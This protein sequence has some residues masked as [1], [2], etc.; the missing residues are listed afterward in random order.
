MLFNIDL[1]PKVALEEMNDVHLEELSM[2]NDIY[3]YLSRPIDHDQN[4][5]EGMLKEFV[6]H[7]HGHFYNEEQMMKET[8]CPILSCHEGEHQRVLSIMVQFLK[9]YALS[10]DHQML[11]DFFEYEFKA[12]I[13]NHIL[14]MD[15]VTGMYL[16]KISMGE[17]VFHSD[18]HGCETKKSL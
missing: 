2:A 13:E 1:M 5:I 14:T 8:N 17:N 15:T 16:S 12:W 9:D 6:L 10:K 3:D 7:V 18:N 11:K 4:T